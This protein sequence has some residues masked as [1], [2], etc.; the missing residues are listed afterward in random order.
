ECRDAACVPTQHS[1][2]REVRSSLRRCS[3][4]HVFA[5]DCTCNRVSAQMSF[6]GAIGIDLRW[7]P[8]QERWVQMNIN[9]Y[10][11]HPANA[12]CKFARSHCRLH[13]EGQIVT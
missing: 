2:L 13:T 7:Y 10:R 1:P 12:R 3:L 9:A 5:S 11:S 8:R 6:P 4:S